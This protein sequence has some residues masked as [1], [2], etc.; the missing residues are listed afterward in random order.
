MYF[1]VK[2]YKMLA[3]FFLKLYIRNLSCVVTVVARL[4]DRNVSVSS[5]LYQ[6][7]AQLQ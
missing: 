4:E 2:E 7:T 5:R 6:F 1:I 3:D